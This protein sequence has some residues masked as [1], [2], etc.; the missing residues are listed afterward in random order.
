LAARVAP[1]APG[2]PIRVEGPVVRRVGAQLLVRHAD[3]DYLVRLPPGRTVPD[4]PGVRVAI[5]GSAVGWDPYYGVV[6][7]DPRSLEVLR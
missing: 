6:H 5:T 2:A 1:R 7:L 4:T 3:Q